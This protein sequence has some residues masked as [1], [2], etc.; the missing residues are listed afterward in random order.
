MVVVVVSGCW[1]LVKRISDYGRQLE[2]AVLGKLAALFRE[3]AFPWPEGNW[4]NI[5]GNSASN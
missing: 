4:V 3:I 1:A 5:L 2:E